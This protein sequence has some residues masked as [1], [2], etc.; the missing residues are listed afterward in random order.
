MN[1]LPQTLA[2]IKELLDKMT[3]SDMF[4]KT[5]HCQERIY[6]TLV[7][8]YNYINAVIYRGEKLE[9]GIV[10]Y[11]LHHLKTAQKKYGVKA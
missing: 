5:K 8:G 9:Q 11:F 1:N 4:R 2:S 7:N 3:R 6:K 10:E